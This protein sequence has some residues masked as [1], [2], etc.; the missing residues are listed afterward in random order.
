MSLAGEVLARWAPIMRNVELR[1]GTQGRVE[2]A[3]DGETIFSKAALGR[4]AAPGEVEGA[5]EKR[6]GKPIAWRQQ[7]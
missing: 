5:I 3:L 1:S 7:H 6:V 2:V 4:H